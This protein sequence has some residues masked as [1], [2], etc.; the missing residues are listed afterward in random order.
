MWLF[1]QPKLTQKKIYKFNSQFFKNP[2]PNYSIYALSLP[3]LFQTST[4]LLNHC[5]YYQHLGWIKK[6]T[7]GNNEAKMSHFV[8]LTKGKQREESQ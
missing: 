4:F 3:P 6:E 1:I 8:A 7:R 5:K 2:R